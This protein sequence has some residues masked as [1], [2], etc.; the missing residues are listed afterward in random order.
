MQKPK[1]VKIRLNELI[2]LLSYA[3][4]ADKDHRLKGMTDMSTDV[5]KAH[6]DSQS[7]LAVTPEQ[8]EHLLFTYKECLG[9][10]LSPGKEQVDDNWNALMKR[11]QKADPRVFKLA[12]N[13][14]VLFHEFS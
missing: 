14:E 10:G 4:A 1:L 11:L 7:E 8:L 5:L 2:T 13:G 6:I 12:D 9:I 3:K